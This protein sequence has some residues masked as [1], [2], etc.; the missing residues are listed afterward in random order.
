MYSHTESRRPPG[1]ISKIVVEAGRLLVEG[2]QL[3]IVTV[4]MALVLF[5]VVGLWLQAPPDS[6]FKWLFAATLVV[7]EA[8]CWVSPRRYQRPSAYGS[9]LLAAMFIFYLYLV[10]WALV[11]Q[12][13][14]PMW[15][16]KPP[17]STHNP[18]TACSQ[19]AG[20][21]NTEPVGAVAA[22][23]VCT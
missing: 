11:V 9:A 8:L 18:G 19:T 22:P 6:I 2:V 1:I 13:V 14:P 20:R 17:V 7:S 16:L 12:T 15:F 23:G 3:F 10:G 4:M 21:Q 5:Y